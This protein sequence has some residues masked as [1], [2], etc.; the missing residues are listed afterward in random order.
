MIESGYTQCLNH[1]GYKYDVANHQDYNLI[2]M[3]NF[4]LIVF[5]KSEA[6]KHPENPKANLAM[7]SIAFA[8]TMA[9]RN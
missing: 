5:R 1:L 7:N 4:L 2:L 3:R 9:V 8:G 6:V